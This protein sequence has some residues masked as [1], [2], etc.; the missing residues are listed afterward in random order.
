[1]R[2]TYEQ[3]IDGM[4]KRLAMYTGQSNLFALRAYLDG[5]LMGCDGEGIPD[6]GIFEYEFHEYVKDRLGYY[7]STAGWS[8]MITAHCMGF[9]PDKVDWS[10]YLRDA[11]EDHHHAA[12]DLLWNLMDDYLTERT[13]IEEPDG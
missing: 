10:D 1:M 6:H 3:L 7:E 8:N 11:T 13:S 4:R 12:V 5:Y 2:P 9:S